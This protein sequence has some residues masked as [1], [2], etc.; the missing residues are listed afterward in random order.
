MDA[1]KKETQQLE[2]YLNEAQTNLL[3]IRNSTDQKTESEEH[4]SLIAELR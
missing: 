1:L 4:E 3:A 2:Q